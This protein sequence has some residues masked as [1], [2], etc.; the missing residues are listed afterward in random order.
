MLGPDRE[1]SDFLG[2]RL[3]NAAVALEKLGGALV[4]AFL[5][6]G[7]VRLPR[8]KRFFNPIAFFQGRNVGLGFRRGEELKGGRSRKG[9]VRAAVFPSPARDEDL[10]CEVCRLPGLFEEIP[11]AEETDRRRLPDR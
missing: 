7:L 9:G 2:Q 5:D 6:R 8:G 11:G 1:I 10:F 3:S 4:H